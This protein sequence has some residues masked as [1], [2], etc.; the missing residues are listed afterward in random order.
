MRRRLINR[1]VLGSILFIL[2]L[3]FIARMANPSEI[4]DI[5]PAIYCEDEYVALSDVL[6]VIPF[7]DNYS[8]ADAVSWC[9]Q[10]K[11]LNKTLGL[12]GVYHTYQEFLIDR[13]AAYIEHGIWAF[14]RCFGARPT[15]FKPPQLKISTHNSELLRSLGLEVF[16]TSHQLTR[17][18]YHCS[19]TGSYPNLLV[20]FV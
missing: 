6:W 10:M 7:Y 20:R 4:D 17:K 15:L 2:I 5:H 18:V 13:D 16:T 14:E 12:H 11:K 8:I 1:L 3:F 19:D 9:A